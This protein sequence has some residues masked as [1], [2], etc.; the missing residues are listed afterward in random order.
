MVPME[1]Q[2]A[3]RR[4][5]MVRDFQAEPVAAEAIERIVRNATRAPSA[6]FTQGWG[7]LILDTPDDVARFWVAA[8]PAPDPAMVNWREGMG[9]APV[10]VI[11]TA[12][13]AEYRRRYD[14]PDKKAAR[15]AV[16]QGADAATSMGLDPDWPVPYWHVDAGMAAM[17]M[18]LTA[19]DEGLGACF[20]G[21]TS[22][23]HAAVHDAFAIPAEHEI[24]GVVAL[25]H[26][27]DP[28]A[29]S[30]SPTRRARRAM[31]DVVHRGTW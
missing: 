26:P 5:K 11:V 4:R 20:F 17:S 12:A 2:D 10:L 7:F 13:E 14:E 21:V 24:T 18:L 28:A 27:S 6:G 9:R 15:A 3:V 29:V 16:A 31:P 22:P 8:S 19:V 30:G 1:F 23:N 25:G